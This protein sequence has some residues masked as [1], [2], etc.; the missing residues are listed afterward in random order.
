MNAPQLHWA[1]VDFSSRPDSTVISIIGPRLIVGPFTVVRVVAAL[2]S[3]E[4]TALLSP[5][6]E[7][8]LVEAR[9]LATWVLRNVPSEPMSYPKIGRVLGDRHHST[10]I[11]LHLM[12]IRLRLEDPA[13]A[14]RCSAIAEYFKHQE[15][16]HACHEHR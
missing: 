1:G 5:R 13:F 11:N 4:E 14:R 12:A 10:I 8:L 2:Y 7:Q 15:A 6:R 9:A 3:I 16:A